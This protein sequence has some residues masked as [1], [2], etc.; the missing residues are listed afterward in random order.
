[1][2]V[3]RVV[4]VRCHDEY[5]CSAEASGIYGC[6]VRAGDTIGVVTD[7]FHPEPE[8]VRYMGD[9][10]RNDALMYIPDT[11]ESTPLAKILVVGDSS[12]YVSTSIPEIG[13]EVYMLS[14]DEIRRFHLSDGEFTMP[15]YLRI[16]EKLDRQ[17]ALPLLMTLLKNL[18]N[19]FPEKKKFLDLLETNIE[20]G[21]KI[22][23]MK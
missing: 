10:S 6:F 9:I 17:S 8:L 1:M 4:E 11:F 18:R 15:Y 2:R 22:Q 20:Y 23:G 3:G 14:E 21:F 19:I 7:I 5:I 12:G 13:E 16:V